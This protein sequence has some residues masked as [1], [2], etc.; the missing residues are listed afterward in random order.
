M[1]RT[2]NELGRPRIIGLAM[3]FAFGLSAWLL[4]TAPAS[5]AA[6]DDP[7]GVCVSGAEFESE[8]TMTDKERGKEAKKNRK[9]K[10]RSLSVELSEGRGSVFVDGVWLGTLPVGDFALKPGKH[11]IVV[12]DKSRVLMTGVLTVPRKG[13]DGIEIVIRAPAS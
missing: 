8:A 9:R 10:D 7:S 13:E 6:C 3:G 1:R 12:R 11:D 5:A 4:P 2:I